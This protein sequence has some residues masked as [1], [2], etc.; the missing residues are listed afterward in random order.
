MKGTARTAR[1][2]KDTKVSC[3]LHHVAWR[4]VGMRSPEMF[5][6]LSKVEPGP[7]HDRFFRLGNPGKSRLSVVPRFLLGR[8]QLVCSRAETGGSSYACRGDSRW[9]EPWGEHR[10]PNWLCRQKVLSYPRLGRVMP[11]LCTQNLQD[12]HCRSLLPPGIVTSIRVEVSLARGCQ[13]PGAPPALKHP[14][15]EDDLRA[16]DLQYFSYF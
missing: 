14:P 10:Q 6:G 15:G 4:S 8:N 11:F 13:P 1:P 16:L 7:A 3:V 5:G 9:A 2:Q 12:W